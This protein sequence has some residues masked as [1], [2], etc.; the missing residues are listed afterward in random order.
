MISLHNIIYKSIK[1]NKTK[2]S[3]PKDVW[4]VFDYADIINKQLVL[5]IIYPHIL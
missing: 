1:S 4:T 2:N 3:E 5:F